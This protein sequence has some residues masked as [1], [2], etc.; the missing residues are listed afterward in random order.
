MELILEKLTLAEW[1]TNVGRFEYLKKENAR[2]VEESG[3]QLLKIAT[4][5]HEV[6]NLKRELGDIVVTPNLD[7]FMKG[8]IYWHEIY[9][10]TK[11]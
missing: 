8:S 9:N 2:L 1:E 4:L 10:A 5:Q 11:K 6:K 7:K 3:A